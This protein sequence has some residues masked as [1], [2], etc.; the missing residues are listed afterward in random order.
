MYADFAGDGDT[1][2]PGVI[3]L[4]LNMVL[5]SPA[6]VKDDFLKSRNWEY[7]ARRQL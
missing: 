3:F 5:S 6:A 1:N 2:P 7:K 4:I